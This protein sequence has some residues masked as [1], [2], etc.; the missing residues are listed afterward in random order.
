MATREGGSG[1]EP[2]LPR[3]WVTLPW[4]DLEQIPSSAIDR[5][6]ETKERIGVPGYP[7]LETLFPYKFLTVRDGLYP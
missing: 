2:I 4:V 1:K 7:G 5:K 3:G 6:L